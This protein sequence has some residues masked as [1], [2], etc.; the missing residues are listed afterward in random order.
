[1]LATSEIG[2]SRLIGSCNHLGLSGKCAGPAGLLCQ[3]GRPVTAA[4]APVKMWRRFCIHSMPLR[5]V[6]R[7][8]R[9]P[10]PLRQPVEA[11]GEGRAPC[12]AEC[13]RAAEADAPPLAPPPDATAAAE[14]GSGPPP[15][16]LQLPAGRGV[17]CLGTD[18][19]SGRRSSPLCGGRGGGL[20]TRTS[21]SPS[22]VRP[23]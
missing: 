22:A 19:P 1:M 11:P 4:A 10:P 21:S 12:S 23:A 6:R 2:R 18:G 8:H 3:P 17:T 14:T 13:Y 7:P 5:A 20:S 9:R 16:P 15:G